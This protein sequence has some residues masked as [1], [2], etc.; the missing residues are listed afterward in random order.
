MGP[1]YPLCRAARWRKATVAALAARGM[2]V[3]ALVTGATWFSCT[4]ATC[5]KAAI[6]AVAQPKQR[7]AA[8]FAQLGNPRRTRS[9]R[10]STGDVITP[11]STGEK[12][13]IV[14]LGSPACVRVVLKSLWQS[15]KDST[16]SDKAGE[17]LS[18]RFEVCAVVSQPP[19]RVKKEISQT[20]VHELA[21]ELGIPCILTP[22][23]AKEEDFLAKLEA[24][25]PD[26]CITA[27]YGQY[28]P[29]RFLQIPRLGTLNLHP[30]LLPRWR[31]ASPVQRA[32]EKGDTET[33]ITI[34][35][36]VS[37]MDAGPIVL[38]RNIPLVGSETT[39]ELLETLFK[40][41]AELLLDEALP[42]VLRGDVTMATAQKQDESLVIQAPLIAKEEGQLW[43]HNET[44][45]QM[46]DKVRGFHGWPG[47]TL[48]VALSGSAAPVQ[49]MRIKVSQAEV[50]TASSLPASLG[51]DGAPSQ[52]L[53]FVP[54]ASLGGVPEPA[55]GLRTAVDPDNVL[56]LRSFQL[57]SKTEVPA[58]TFFKGYMTTQPARWM[59]P[60]E[61]E[62]LTA[63]GSG[64]SPT[65]VKKMRSR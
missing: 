49:G 34:L 48:G 2:A 31:G 38:Q 32:L 24:M 58:V 60:D 65:R 51:L 13:R 30:S 22:E 17:A 16:K 6:L 63:T 7:P 55:V 23:T 36:T 41:G 11:S 37:K 25:R 43:P 21:E 4:V 52:E 59:R 18:A 26:I 54:S 61:E 53:F 40:W 57:P 45:Y 44:S 62:Q 19:K 50:V 8:T 10:R 46:R 5:G 14:F 1:M 15:A 28:L 20:P 29:K 3:M 47:T 39:P 12:A 27:A 33:G 42:R 56:L 64:G 35:Y 9:A